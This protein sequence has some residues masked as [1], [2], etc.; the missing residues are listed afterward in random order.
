M[1]SKRYPTDLTDAQWEILKPMVEPPCAEETEARAA[2]Q[3]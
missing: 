2:T 3:G 1:T